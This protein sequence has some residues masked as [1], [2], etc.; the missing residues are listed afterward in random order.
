MARRKMILKTAVGTILLAALVLTVLVLV[1]D[2]RPRPR[3]IV[4]VARGMVF[5]LD[6]DPRPNPPLSLEAGERVRLVLRN[7]DLGFVH[8]VAVPDWGVASERVPSGE[9]TAIEF[10]VPPRPGQYEYRCT[11]HGR[12]MRGSITVTAR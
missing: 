3:A 8:N 2:T 11:L 1:A 4:L 10:K 5:H 7:E 12:M 9:T 6:A